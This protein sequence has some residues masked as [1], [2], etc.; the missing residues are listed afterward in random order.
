[1]NGPRKSHRGPPPL[2]EKAPLAS[3][4]GHSRREPLLHPTASHP[5]SAD[6]VLFRLHASS[7][8]TFTKQCINWLVHQPG[9]NLRIGAG[10]GSQ[11]SHRHLRSAPTSVHGSLPSGHAPSARAATPA[12]DLTASPHARASR[13]PPPALNPQLLSPSSTLVFGREISD[14]L[15]DFNT[16][17][18]TKVCASSQRHAASPTRPRSH[19]PVVDATSC[20]TAALQL[21]ANDAH[22]RRPRLWPRRPRSR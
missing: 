4:A 21:P 8:R 2:G 16:T 14:S 1:M 15:L 10:Q 12:H 11:P 18:M 22:S 20:P 3:F 7:G 9:L 13:T 5:V 17:S 6:S 19:A